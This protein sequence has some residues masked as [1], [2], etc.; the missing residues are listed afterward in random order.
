MPLQNTNLYARAETGLA[1][2]ELCNV[3][4]LLHDGGI[5][6]AMRMMARSIKTNAI[7]HAEQDRLFHRINAEKKDRPGLVRRILRELK[8]GDRAATR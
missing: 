6:P 3:M 1:N 2:A 4:V 8:G 5:E 7:R